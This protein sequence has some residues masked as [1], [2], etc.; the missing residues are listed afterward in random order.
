MRQGHWPWVPYHVHVIYKLNFK[1]YAAGALGN[2]A[3]KEKGKNKLN[4]FLTA[5]MAVNRPFEREDVMLSSGLPGRG[6]LTA[7]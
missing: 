6:C 5:Y 3:R 7:R 4:D 2:R 1:A